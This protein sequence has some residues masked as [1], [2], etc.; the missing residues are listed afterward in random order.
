[1]FKVRFGI[2]PEI[3][4]DVFQIE[5]KPYNPRHK[6]L[7][8]SNNVR[9]VNSGTHTA[10]FVGSRIWYTILEVCQIQIKNTN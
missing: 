9:S 8:K 2:A 1:M 4:K 10:S 7:I 6:F 3:M 5:D